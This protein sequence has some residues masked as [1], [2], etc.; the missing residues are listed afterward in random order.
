VTEE[1]IFRG[2]LLLR[3]SAISRSRSFAIGLS[4]IVFAMGH[5][6]EGQVGVAA[7]ALLGFVF[8]VIYL[9]TGSLV[10]PIVMHFLQDFIAVVV[11]PLFTKGQ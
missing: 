3:F 11:V 7:V 8:A 9:R 4:T 5:A 2:Y 6:Y 1:T 10:A